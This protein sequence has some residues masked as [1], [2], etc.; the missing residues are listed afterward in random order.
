LE[1]SWEKRGTRETMPREGRHTIQQGKQ[2]GRPWETRPRE[3]R[4]TIQQMRTSVET[5]G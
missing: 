1:T 4:R 3:G 2:E 5:R